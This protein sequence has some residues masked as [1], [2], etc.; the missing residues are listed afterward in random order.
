MTI[1]A[2]AYGEV[3]FQDNFGGGNFNADDT[4]TATTP[5]AIPGTGVF[6]KLTNNALGPQTTNINAPTNITELWKPS[7][8]QFDFSQ[9][10]LGDIV[11]IRSDILVDIASANTDVELQFQAGIGVTSFAI[12][13]DA[14]IFKA[15]GV[16]QLSQTS[17]LTMDTTTI[18]TGKAEFQLKADKACDVEVNGWNY[19][20]IRRADVA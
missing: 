8:N 15:T 1:L 20:I 19:V 10:E 3:L 9:L 18:L 11:I 4:L 17:M 6:T 5:I 12:H 7:T 14:G 13:W 2:P 16:F